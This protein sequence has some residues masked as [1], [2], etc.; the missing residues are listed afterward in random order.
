MTLPKTIVTLVSATAAL[1]LM[2]ALAA[3]STTQV[4]TEDVSVKGYDLAETTDANQVFAKI[5]QAAERVCTIVGVRDNARERILRRACASD[6][7]ANAVAAL[8]APEVTALMD[9]KSDQ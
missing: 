4:K 1:S 2:P 6:A 9:A 5:E 8:N 7:I 3:I